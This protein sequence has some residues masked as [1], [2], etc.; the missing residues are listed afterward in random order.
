MTS[1]KSLQGMVKGLREDIELQKETPA[2]L[3]PI[4]KLLESYSASP[5]ILDDAAR[6]F[7]FS[8]FSQEV[9]R[10]IS[11]VSEARSEAVSSLPL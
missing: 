8:E 4:L 10:L 11:R 2:S 3:A 7:F 6:S 5:E 1:L 9:V